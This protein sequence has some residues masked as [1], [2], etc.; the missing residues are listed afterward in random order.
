MLQ[1]DE[2]NRISW[3]DIFKRFTVNKSQKDMVDSGSLDNLDT[4]ITQNNLYMEDN[5]VAGYLCQMLEQHPYQEGVSPS[6]ST[7]K[8]KLSNPQNFQSAQS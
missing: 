2:T 8:N 7:S 3:P 4:I 5:L 6:S 1:Y